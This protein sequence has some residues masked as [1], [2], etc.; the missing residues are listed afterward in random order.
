MNEQWILYQT[1][2]NINGKIYVGVHKLAD[3]YRSKNYLGSGDNLQKAIKKYKRENFTRITLAEFSCF[4]DAYAAEAGMVTEEFIKRSDTYNMSLGGWG[5]VNLTKEMRA[6][7]IAANTGRKASPET[8]A[9]MAE[10]AKGNKSHLGK[11]HSDETK[12]KLS[13]M[14]KGKTATEEVKARMSAAKTGVPLSEEHKAKI[15]AR[16]MGNKITLGRK[17]SEEAKK[18]LSISKGTAIVVNDKYFPSAASA[19]THEKI[20]HS[21]ILRR[22]RSEDPK[23]AGYRYAT[24]EEKAAHSLEASR[25]ST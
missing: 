3:N 19:S 13:A 6:K 4:E 23:F 14:F 2:N 15:S 8:R 1:T 22:V 24:P 21:S 9:K 20:N 16:M 11:K 25:Q 10:S 12:A 5:G 18:K 17:H 7:L